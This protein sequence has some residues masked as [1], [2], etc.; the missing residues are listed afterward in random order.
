[1]AIETPG[2]VT[3]ER[4]GIDTA[5]LAP[6][7]RSR[8][9][10]L[11][12]ALGGLG[13]LVA[14]RLAVPGPADAAA[15]DPLVI[16]STTN[17]AGTANTSLTTA[18]A[19]TA[20]LVTQNGGGTALRGSAVGPG[21]I[22]GF[23]TAAN[24]TGVSGVTGNPGAYGVFA[25]NDD[26]TYGGGGAV[27]ASGKNNN[28][29]VAT[30]DNGGANAIKA[31]NAGIGGALGSA[32][33]ADAG[34]NCTGV[35]G[36]AQAAPGVFGFAVNAPGVYGSSTNEIGVQGAGNPGVYGSSTSTF[37]TGMEGVGY[38]TSGH[39]VVGTALADSGNAGGIYGA[40]IFS[41]AFAGYFEG[42]VHATGG[43]TGPTAAGI[44]IDHPLEPAD[45]VLL[46]SA[47]TSDDA[48]TIY[49]GTVTTD[50][51]GE[52][53]VELPAWFEALNTDLR[54]Q[55]TV[56]GSFAQAMVKREVKN[57]RF[58]IATSEPATKVSWQLTGVRH[59]AYAR[60]HPRTVESVK[61]GAERNTY[62]NPV[63][64]GQPESKGFDYPMRQLIREPRPAVTVPSLD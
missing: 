9:A 6:P 7:P 3:P 40:A 19:G 46:H 15:G 1:M 10:L 11:A 43:I 55:L 58:T 60:A 56:I 23:F 50:G 13:G 8:R 26:A 51:Q 14:S 29:V 48:L 52:A 25:S 61:T 53:T 4:V 31:A 33:L 32:I 34:L 39:G 20:L 44:R 17:T 36:R 63:E 59:D 54:Y 22:A 24:G 37:G 42:K 45:K 35:S 47:V 2:T 62:L 38:G 27:R 28:G 12:A 57:N 21:S 16:G 30:T 18:S 5:A 41:S 64:H 49:A